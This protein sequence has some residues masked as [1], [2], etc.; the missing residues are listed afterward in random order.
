MESYVLTVTLNPALDKT[1]VVE[2]FNVGGLN[3]VQS[4]RI[5]AGGK[6][7]NVARVLK[8]FNINV[9]ATGLIAGVQGQLLLE[10]LE[11]DGIKN[12]FL[13]EHGNTR[14]NL[15][16]IDKHSNL[17]TEINEMGFSVST[18]VLNEFKE[19]Y[20]RLI[21]QA[22]F[23]VISGS[24]PPGIDNGIYYELIEIARKEGVKAILDADGEVLAEG[25]KAL[26]FAIKPNIFELEM[27]FGKKLTDDRD[28]VNAAKSLLD[29]GIK[30]VI[31]SMGA[32]GAIVLDEK[33]VYRV[34]SYE[35][36]RKSATGAGDSMVAA[37]VYCLLNGYS[38]FEI[39]RWTTAAGTITASKPGTE[40]CSFKEVQEVLDKIQVERI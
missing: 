7:I 9:L 15:K 10:Y 39:A 16:I 29:K 20:T 25:I 23:V 28:I 33:E 27:L 1:I 22:M 26:P 19:K 40:V 31:V 18:E 35:I 30:I 5:D 12:D 34:K 38:L 6:G 2:K 36:D 8:K 24:L 11:K 21:K 13:K 3:R 17:V 32:D 37:L 4:M 14:T